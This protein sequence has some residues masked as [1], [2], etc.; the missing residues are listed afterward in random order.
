MIK[1]KISLVFLLA[2]TFG[3]FLSLSYINPYNGEI[4]L[5]ELVL[6]MSGSRGEFIMGFSAVELLDFAM[7]M[8]PG[9]LV[10]IFLGVALY[11]HFCTASIYVF[12]R[13]E[14]RKRWYWKEMLSLG[15]QIFSFQTLLLLSAVV[16]AVLRFKVIMNV[17]GFVLALYHILLHF[18]W[19]YSATV[20]VNLLALKFGSSASFAI[21]MSGQAA[22]IGMFGMGEMLD[23]MYEDSFAA[24]TLLIKCNP[25]SHL[26]LG[27]HSSYIGSVNTVLE[28]FTGRF[29]DSFYMEISAVVLLIVS[30]IILK[31][32][33]VIV[34]KYDL[35]ISDA[36]MGVA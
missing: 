13:C 14:N 11:R 24:K 32:G 6:Q 8:I 30:V 10:E 19:V 25:V 3:L 18:L 34:S 36:E 33:S 16:T 4:T 29:C 12:A 22:G 26:V 1:R 23:R 20:L 9:W 15:I 35:L 21:V 27:W 2:V 5:S 31:T 7:Q 28:S 17:E